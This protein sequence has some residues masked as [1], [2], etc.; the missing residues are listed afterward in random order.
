ML[1][2]T[3]WW[4]LAWRHRHLVKVSEDFAEKQLNNGWRRS[5]YTPEANIH[6]FWSAPVE[7]YSTRKDLPVVRREIPVW[8]AADL[9][10]LSR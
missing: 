4:R 10:N 3:S 1:R 9:A 7:L 2:P 5:L 8:T 6:L